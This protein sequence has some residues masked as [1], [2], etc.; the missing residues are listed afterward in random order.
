M[1]Y[2]L[3]RIFAQIDKFYQYKDYKQQPYPWYYIYPYWQS[4][5]RT[6][7][8]GYKGYAKSNIE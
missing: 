8:E 6:Q 7:P 4:K 5:A 3:H 2:I 1:V